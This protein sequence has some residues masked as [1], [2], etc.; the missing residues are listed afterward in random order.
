MAV[1]EV[2]QHPNHSWGTKRLWVGGGCMTQQDYWD[3]MEGRTRP[4][5]DTYVKHDV[6]IQAAP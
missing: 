2:A 4:L 3:A 6:R 1:K 5:G